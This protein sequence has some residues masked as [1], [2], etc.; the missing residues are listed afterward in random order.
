MGIEI[1]CCF[2]LPE[3]PGSTC[4]ERS[5]IDLVVLTCLSQRLRGRNRYLDTPFHFGL[6]WLSTTHMGVL[7]MRIAGQPRLGA[8][9]HLCC[10]GGT[11]LCSKY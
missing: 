1:I 4:P 3:Q 9:S 6:V 11:V 8:Q 10:S 5:S 7:P 2:Y